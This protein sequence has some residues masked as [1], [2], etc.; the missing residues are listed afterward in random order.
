MAGARNCFVGGENIGGVDSATPE[1]DAGAGSDWKEP[2]KGLHGA[3]MEALQGVHPVWQGKSGLMI[4]GVWEDPAT[5]KV[6]LQVRGRP[7]ITPEDG[8]AGVEK[9]LKDN[10]CHMSPATTEVK[11]AGDH[12]MGFDSKN[13]FA[14]APPWQRAMAMTFSRYFGNT[15]EA[16]QSVHGL[17]QQTAID[18]L[19]RWERALV[20]LDPKMHDIH[21]ILQNIP[22]SSFNETLGG[23][24]VNGVRWLHI[25]ALR[26]LA[27]L[28]SDEVSGENS[29]I[30]EQLGRISASDEAAAARQREHAYTA[31]PNSLPA[32]FTRGIVEWCKRAGVSYEAAI[33]YRTALHLPERIAEVERNYKAALEGA[34][35]S[36]QGNISAMFAHRDNPLQFEHATQDGK[37]LRGMEAHEAYMNEL[38]PEQKAKLEAVNQFITGFMDDLTEQA[39]SQGL[40]SKERVDTL[41]ETSRNYV[42]SRDEVNDLY[43]KTF[44]AV[45]GRASAAQNTEQQLLTYMEV[46]NHNIQ[47]NIYNRHLVDIMKSN[48]PS[49]VWRLED[50]AYS[51]ASTAHPYDISKGVSVYYPGPDPEAPP[52]ARRLS[53]NTDTAAGKQLAD[54]FSRKPPPHIIQVLGGYTR[55]SSIMMTAARPAWMLKSLAWNTFIT[56]AALQGAFKLEAHEASEILFG[57]NNKGGGF[58]KHS[59]KA[60]GHTLREAVTGEEPKGLDGEWQQA[61]NDYGIGHARNPLYDAT[62]LKATTQLNSNESLLK[63]L[64]DAPFSGS[65][66]LGKKAWNRYLRMNQSPEAAFQQGAFRASVEHFATKE[67]VTLNSAQDIRNFL[68]DRPDLR[69]R[70]MNG[71]RRIVPDFSQS[72]NFRTLNTIFPFF[73]ASLQ[74][75]PYLGQLAGTSHGMMGM[76]G[77]MLLGYYGA[78]TM[79][80]ENGDAAA[81]NMKDTGFYLGHGFAVPTDYA[82]KPALAMGAALENMVAGGK[83]IGDTLPEIANSFVSSFSPIDVPYGGQ[84][85]G[86]FLG[87]HIAPPSI[88]APVTALVGFDAFGNR[89]YNDNP[90]DAD[91]H[92]LANPAGWEEGRPNDSAVATQVAKLLYYATGKMI[93]AAPGQVSAFMQMGLPSSDGTLSAIDGEY[94]ATHGE[95][96][97]LLNAVQSVFAPNFTQDPAT[98]AAQRDIEAKYHDIVGQEG[99]S[100]QDLV[101]GLAGT[102]EQQQAARLVKSLK[103]A[104]GNATI[105]TPLGPMTLTKL[106][107]LITAAR[108]EGGLGAA[109]DLLLKRAALKQRIDLLWSVEGQALLSSD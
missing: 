26:P 42:P 30:R 70:I 4:G 78:Q 52:I 51:E 33:R 9:Y 61:M 28:D 24:F 20:N 8:W 99:F 29:L 14:A 85:L 41:R 10:Y 80:E 73:N 91:G 1:D 105:D 82:Y 23:R 60:L 108:Q 67:G 84:N 69:D 55:F 53:I 16:S 6:H 68:N 19:S 17:M 107:H 86:V 49:E 47:R 109:R 59:F 38:G 94:A 54:I 57:K 98:G 88:V 12:I 22:S 103:S 93:D 87:E 56:P 3:N 65:L 44:G 32:R 46:M 89:I 66:E 96:A 106:N 13:A 92:R 37:T 71:T 83:T 45:R 63:G 76:G 100:E 2:G 50:I 15:A 74:T 31:G 25:N 48:S 11:V 43:G 27:V 90:T 5:G 39:Y 81:N 75:L 40:L 18:H 104:A 77:M 101:S 34:S 64:K 62:R 35:P 97:S 95:N 58:F 21:T 79:R 36:E 72:G 102:P 7:T